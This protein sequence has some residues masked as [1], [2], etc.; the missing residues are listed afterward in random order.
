MI[1]LSPQQ[2][3]V[4]LAKQ[5]MGLCS[6]QQNDGAAPITHQ[7]VYATSQPIDPQWPF[8]G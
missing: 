3:G 4:T 5:Q 6:T 7:K 8:H 2:W 1:L